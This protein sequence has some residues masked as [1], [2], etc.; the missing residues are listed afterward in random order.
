ADCEKNPTG[1]G[2]SYIRADIYAKILAEVWVQNYATIQAKGL[3]LVTGGLYAHD[4]GGNGVGYAA[5]DYMTEAYANGV[6]SGFLQHYGRPYPWD[7]F[8]YH[9]YTTLYGPPVAKSTLSSYLDGIAAA[10]AAHNDKSAIWMTEFGWWTPQVSE[11]QQAA[12]LDTELGVL[13][14]RAD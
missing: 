4:V 6:G 8:G 10:R 11:A 14:A 3:H 9:V 5:D 2:G 1:A 12:N 13:E 7:G